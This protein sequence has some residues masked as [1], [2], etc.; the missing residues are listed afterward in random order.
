MKAKK[1]EDIYGRI[2]KV[3][4]SKVHTHFYNAFLE[5]PAMIRIVREISV[6]DKKAL[7]LGCGTGRYAT[8]LLHAGAKVWG[9]DPSKEM[10]KIAKQGNRGCNFRVGKAENL[11]YRPNFFD[12]VVSGL[13]IHYSEN[14]EKVFLGVNRVLKSGGFFVFSTS[15]P[16][17]E[18]SDRVDSR[19]HT[20][21]SYFK[22]GER[23]A[24][25]PHFGVTVPYYHVTLETLINAIIQNGFIIE[26]YVDAKPIRAAEHAFP[27]EYKQALNKPYFCIFKLRKN[28]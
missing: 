27:K 9:I 11:P 8:L 18:I 28:L 25:M 4:H 3:Y 12:V 16:V 2:A 10:I 22:E 26:K 19:H 20:F 7:D 5:M 23:K 15:N 13:A 1:A 6:K 21:D 24:H 17:T 14:L